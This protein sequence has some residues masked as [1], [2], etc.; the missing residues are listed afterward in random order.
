[1]PKFPKPH[2]R[3]YF[4]RNREAGNLDQGFAEARLKII[5]PVH[6]RTL[7]LLLDPLQT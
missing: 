5:G 6:I 2:N 1:M 7:G 3:E 4:S